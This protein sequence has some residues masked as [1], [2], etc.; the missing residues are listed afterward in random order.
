MPEM[1]RNFTKGKMNKDLDERLVPPGEYRDAMNIQVSTSDESDVGTVQNILG[2]FPGCTYNNAVSPNPIPEYSTTVGSIS[3]EKNDTLYWLVAGFSNINN[4]LPLNPGDN[5]SF[6]DII[7]RTNHS[8]VSG[9]EP[10]FVDKYSFVVYNESN[11]NAPTNTITLDNEDWYANITPGM[12][13][14]GYTNWGQNNA[15]ELFTDVP[16]VHV[17]NMEIQGLQ[18]ESA[19]DTTPVAT[20]TMH[21]AMVVLNNVTLFDPNAPL[22]LPSPFQNMNYYNYVYI[23]DQ[24]YSGEDINNIIG[25]TF[26]LLPGTDNEQVFTIV[27]AANTS[28]TYTNT[29]LSQFVI[30]LTLD[31]YLDVWS[32]EI[33]QDYISPI[34]SLSGLGVASSYQGQSINATITSIDQVSLPPTSVITVS[35]NSS[36]LLVDIYSALFDDN[37]DETGFSLK[38]KNSV[39]AGGVWP[40]DTCIDPTS[41]SSINDDEYQM[42][43]CSDLTTLVLP[44]DY[45]NKALTFEIAG[46]NAETVLNLA[47]EVQLGF[48]GGALYFRND[49]V[50]KFHPDRLITG[51][52]IVDDMLF[53][54]DNYSEPK[55]INIPRSI[56]GTDPHGDTHTMNVNSATSDLSPIKEEHVTV[57][58]KGPKNALSIDLKSNRDSDKNYSGII[59][60][61]S[62]TNVADSDFW[63]QRGSPGPA[64]GA[65]NPYDFSSIT[66]EEGSN[67]F[68]TQI[69]SDLS[70]NANFDL[71]TWKVGAKV[72]L[73]E[74][75]DDTAPPIPIDDYT[76]KGTIIDWIYLG[77]DVNSFTS[78]EPSWGAKVAIKVDSISRLP[79]AADLNNTLNYAIDLFDEAERLFEFKLPR[80]SYR[81]KYEDGEYS[82]FGPWTKPAFLPGSFDYHPNQGYNLGMTNKIT[83]LYLRDFINTDLPLDVVEIDLLYK[84]ESSP[85]IYVV[86]TIRPDSQATIPNEYGVKFNNWQLNEFLIDNENIKTI[87]PSNQFLRAWDTVPKTA[88]SQEITGNRIVYGNYK[89]NYD[90]Q[91]NGSQYNP[92]FSSC[93][94]VENTSSITS[95]KS[96]REY[97]L[98]VVFTDKHGRE[99]PVIS[100]NTG[101]FKV[102]KDQSSIANRLQLNIKNDSIPH[103][104]EYYKFYIKETSGEYYNMAMDRYWDAEDGNMWVS[105]PS[106]DRDK[107]DIDSILILKKGVDADTPVKEPAK[108]KV[109]AIENEAPDFIKLNKTIISDVQ[110]QG[111]SQQIPAQNI[112]LTGDNELPK[113]GENDFALAYWDGSNH[114]YSNTAIKN[115]HT[116]DSLEGDIYFQI[117]NS[118]R[119][120]SSK[121]IKIA[122]IDVTND[123]W[124]QEGPNNGS[125]DSELVKWAIRLEEPFGNDINKFTNSNDGN[126]TA[127]NDGNRAIFWNHKNHYLQILKIHYCL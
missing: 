58:R 92:D 59:T 111:P 32:P 80:F 79:E 17:G 9:C 77:N 61:S 69:K 110:H 115:L 18:Y 47:D 126:G 34:D 5:I 102:D 122:K 121:P 97:Q 21:N 98:G 123:M 46:E 23:V 53:W 82:T 36:E 118:T 51:I 119:T 101:T 14:S 29:G 3:D 90:L 10:V 120:Q 54:T 12:T 48:G 62:A 103:D 93:K 67:I 7:M 25:D 70:G 127:I 24:F 86:E 72:V 88:L 124:N 33:A 96:L 4:Y 45:S 40:Q 28:V 44:Y 30:K 112:F 89:Q 60:I 81:Y 106:N 78:T 15:A 105:F 6:K 56:S 50:L 26:T 16:I 83:H 38:V 113:A 64:P 91:V 116:Q 63:D 57:I 99:T 37:G 13:V 1:K 114:V 11:S 108:F 109:L 107:I 43:K 125:F 84:E 73:K 71:N 27:S 35:P 52:N 65:S 20:T 66:T 41:V 85:S 95:I 74:F 19:Q 22:G 68:R 8:S 76:I 42:V 75:T 117:T 31:D 104:M 2:N 55:K 49:R 100:N 39:G 94:P 87:L